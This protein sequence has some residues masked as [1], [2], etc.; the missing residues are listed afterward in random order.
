M[1]KFVAILNTLK[2]MMMPGTRCPVVG[3]ATPTRKE[4][5]LRLRGEKSCSAMVSI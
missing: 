1:K 3:G 5:M 4:T 2:A